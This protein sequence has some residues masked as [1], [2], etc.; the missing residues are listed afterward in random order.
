MVTVIFAKTNL[1]NTSFPESSI[2]DQ[3]VEMEPLPVTILFV[4]S[5]R[6]SFINSVKISLNFTLQAILLT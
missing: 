5:S 6:V 3:V 1:K 2:K 4:N